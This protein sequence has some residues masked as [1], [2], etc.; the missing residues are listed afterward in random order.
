MN[1][2]PGYKRKEPPTK[3]ELLRKTKYE[4]G[5]VDVDLFVKKLKQDG[6]TDIKIE[7]CGGGTVKVRLLSDDT[8]ITIEEN[9]THIVCG[10]KENL[11]LKVRD[12]LLKCVPSF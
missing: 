3:E 1:D 4:W 11:R 8:V 7:Q 10:G 9:S 6:I 5:Q 12:L 2:Q